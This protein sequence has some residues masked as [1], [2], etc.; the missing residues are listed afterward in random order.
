MKLKHCGV[1]RFKPSVA[2][3]VVIANMVGTG[4]FTSL[5]F[6]LLEIRSPFV[7]L[8][9]WAVGGLTAL[10]GALSYAELGAALPRSGGEY[11]FLSRI[12]HP[13]AGFISGWVS[14][15]VGFAAPTALA[16]LT[17]GSYFS[18]VFPALQPVWLA[19]TLIIL[20]TA[21]HC[22]SHRSSGGAQSLLTVLK[23]L[24]IIGFSIL[25]L[26]LADNPEPVS[27]LPATGDAALVSSGAFAVALIYVSYAYSGWN[28]ATYISG[29]L[30]H[31]QSSLP[32]VLV[33][34]TALVCLSYLL[35]NYVFLYTTP[36]DA[37][38][39]KVEIGFVAAGY[40][41]GEMGAQVMGML[42]ALLLISTV[43]AMI[44]AGPRVL[45][46]IGQDFAPFR[47]LARENKDGI[48]V[49]AILLQSS[50]ALVFLWSA[51]FESILVLSGATMG[52]NT[53]FTVLGL[54][55]LRWR[56]P[57]L[58][59]PYRTWLYPLPP[60]VFLGITS[61][62]LLYIVAKRPAEALACL[63]ILVSG[64]IC[65]RFSVA[66]GSAKS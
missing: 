18:S 15:T 33:G 11:N 65:Y 7:L 24:L 35:L 43:S 46:V 37:M 44:L 42:L 36:M 2:A 13:A 48:P 59:R 14:A 17:F 55:V 25:A 29:E 12:Y 28:A 16:A 38:A 57:Q 31:P 30:E 56:Q 50:I 52:L 63:A 53:F 60:L 20:L 6:Q 8:L 5:G 10:C 22:F 34:S 32:R 45:H 19:T 27:F 26:L 21:V 54:F 9:L 58:P 47:R 4:V 49:T 64:G 3:A 62:T 66:Y 39:G 51:S 41:F 40:I 23:L 1:S 61:W